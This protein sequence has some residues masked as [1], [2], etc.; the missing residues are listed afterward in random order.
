L[1]FEHG[2]PIERVA[3]ALGVSLETPRNYARPLEADEG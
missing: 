2:R 3:R 1:A